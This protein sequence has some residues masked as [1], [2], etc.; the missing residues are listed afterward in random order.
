MEDEAVLQA[1]GLISRESWRTQL[2]Y[3]V[4][5]AWT[6]RNRVELVWYKQG[7]AG[8]ETGFLGLLDFLYKPLLKP[9]SGGF[10]LQYGETDGYNSRIYAYENDVMYSYSIPA[11]SGKG[12]RYYI[13]VQLDA[14]KNWTFWGKW[15]QTLF[16]G[17]KYAGIGEE[18]PDKATGSAF[19]I[20]L[21]YIF[22]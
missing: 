4:S 20:Q 14:G 21:R 10:R 2:N 9:W 6:L 8:V 13:N 17:K 12:F 3:K 15:G 5:P 1:T 22:Q 19:R 11:F 7:G 16:S 18:L